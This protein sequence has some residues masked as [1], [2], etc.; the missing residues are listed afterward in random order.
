MGAI[1]DKLNNG[2]VTYAQ[3]SDFRLPW[4]SAPNYQPNLIQ[5]ASYTDVDAWLKA[6]GMDFRVDTRSL[7]VK[8]ADGQ[9]YEVPDFVANRRDD[10]LNSGEVL[11]VVSPDFKNVN[12][13][14]LIGSWID[15]IKSA[16]LDLTTMGAM[17]KGRNIFIG[18]KLSDAYKTQ[19]GPDLVEGWLMLHTRFDGKGATVASI[20]S[21]CPVCENTVE[22][23]MSEATRK[24]SLFRVPHR[25]V[26]DGDMLRAAVEAADIEV[27]ERAK[28][29]NALVDTK[30][31]E[32]EVLDYFAKD[33]LQFETSDLTKT[34]ADGKPVISVRTQNNLTALI[35]S[36]RR[37]P[38]ALPRI[39]T[40]W[41][42]FQAVTN[43]VDNEA[44]TRDTAGDGE[45]MARK[46]T[47][48]YGRGKEVKAEALKAIMARAKLAPVLLAA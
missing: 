42:A 1:P 12:P 9:Y 48:M 19:V 20:S 39:G 7:F 47:S 31:S 35:N 22:A 25:S 21:V 45:H 18:C 30:I 43:Y 26:F 13:A 32:D 24:G 37:G 15:H 46:Y 34:K 36:Y 44:S 29:F 38:G 4:W 10:M 3:R 17:K 11:G 16:K 5:P 33:I 14:Q 27:K 41:G 40:A 6:A 8:G 23:S 2:V 28:V